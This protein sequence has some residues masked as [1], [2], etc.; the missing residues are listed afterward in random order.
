[1]VLVVIKTHSLYAEEDEVH[2]ALFLNFRPHPILLKTYFFSLKYSDTNV[3]TNISN[4]NLV[5]YIFV[6]MIENQTSVCQICL[7]CTQLLCGTILFTYLMS[8]LLMG[9]YYVSHNCL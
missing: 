8:T 5:L 9:S 3:L 1:M 2:T 7:Y 6:N 4:K